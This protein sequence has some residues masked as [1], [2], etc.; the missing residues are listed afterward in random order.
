MKRELIIPNLKIETSLPQD[1]CLMVLGGRAP[2]PEWLKSITFNTKIWAVDSG[3][4]SCF[5][6]GLTP[7]RLIGD[8]DSA[9]ASSW[10]RAED[11]RIPIS[12]FDKEKDFTDF[13]LALDILV[14][15]EI[16]QNGVFITGCFGGRFDHLWSTVVSFLASNAAYKP[17]G[18]AD[19]LEGLIFLEG[20]ASAV[21]TFSET[22]EAVS[23]IPFTKQCTGISMDGV[24]WP[25]NRALLEYNMPYSIS[26]RTESSNI[27]NFSVESGI[28]GIYWKWNEV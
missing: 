1:I 18:A 17:I 5:K 6:A 26:N 10:Q 21:L 9:S 15:S 27:I 24:R 25:L 23:V 2:E 28:V 7:D 12:K 4:D 20:E 3:L 19:E 16:R 14:K 13:Q 11:M 22:P 8:G